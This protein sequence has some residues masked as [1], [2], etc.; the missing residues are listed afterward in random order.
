M[1]QETVRVRATLKPLHGRGPVR[2]VKTKI[3]VPVPDSIEEAIKTY[4]GDDVLEMI[5]KEV[6]TRERLKAYEDLVTQERGARSERIE[7]EVELTARKASRPGG[8]ARVP[9]RGAEQAR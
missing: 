8:L 7:E 6:M 4:G 9:A 1:H 3:R 5:G 2:I